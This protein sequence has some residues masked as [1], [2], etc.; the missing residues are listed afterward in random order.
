MIIFS[1]IR[2]THYLYLT[3][4]TRYTYVFIFM[5]F[6]SYVFSK[7]YFVS[8]VGNAMNSGSLISPWDLQTALNHPASVMPGDTIWLRQGIYTGHFISKLK[9]I[10]SQYIYLIQFPGERATIQDNRQYASGATLQV[11]GEWAIYK[12][13]EVSNITIDRSSTGPFSFR[14]MGLQILAPHSKFINLIIHDTGHGI[15]FWEEA[16]D[17]E[18]YACIIFNC[19]TQNE[20][21]KYTTHGHGIYAQN[22]KGLKVIKNNIIFNQFGFGIHLY[23]NPG[24]VNGFLLE[25]NTIFNCGI[26]TQ[27]TVRFNNILATTYSPY[28][29]ENIQLI[30]NL[31]YDSRKQFY[32]SSIYQANIFLGAADVIS[33]QLIVKDN[34]FLSNARAGAAII[35]WKSVEFFNNSLF[36]KNG[37]IGLLVP[38][39]ILST[40]YHWN[41][42]NYFSGGNNLSFSY[43]SSPNLNFTTWQQ[44]SKLDAQSTFNL[45]SP[46]NLEIIYQKNKYDTG[47]CHILIYNWNLLPF[48]NLD[49]SKSG[50][51]NGQKYKIK[52]VQNYFGNSLFNGVYDELNPYFNLSSLGLITQAPIGKSALMNTAPEFISLIIIPEDDEKTFIQNTSDNVNIE[53]FP[54]PIQNEIHIFISP[55]GIPIKRITICDVWGHL[56]PTSMSDQST[57]DQCLLKVNVEALAKGVYFIQIHFDN[58]TYIKKIVID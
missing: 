17:S 12:D 49:L 57:T 8:I 5:L 47:R 1:Y 11:E 23:P 53:L 45:D 40:R 15:G 52:D 29:L 58:N 42:N 3:M 10:S 50:L 32:Y 44:E 21:T 36:H 18:I 34:F 31:S 41:E 56:I 43:Q 28:T 27:D 54:N 6:T 24:Q 16:I 2:D 4:F 14:P 9:G 51:I 55:Y 37:I 46:K 38:S 22:T 19:G 30:G 7:Q 33:D 25:G 20:V 13:F 48:V 35:N 26:L 39:G